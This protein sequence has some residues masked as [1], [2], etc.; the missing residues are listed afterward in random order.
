MKQHITAIFRFFHSFF[1][2][3]GL[4]LFLF[5]IRGNLPGFGGSQGIVIAEVRLCLV[6]AFIFSLTHTFI[7]LDGMSIRIKLIIASVLGSFTCGVLTIYFGIPSAI[8][9][10]F[11]ITDITAATIAWFVGFFFCLAIFWLF[12]LAVECYYCHL[13][14]QYNEALAQYKAKSDDEK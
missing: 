6:T 8:I 9:T 4:L 12:Y 7:I 13:G 11:N 3:F 14:R 5:Y 1:F 2:T 10:W